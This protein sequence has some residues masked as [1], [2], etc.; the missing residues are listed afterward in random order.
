[1]DDVNISFGPV[2]P[3]LSPRL[4][5]ISMPPLP[6]FCD[7]K[8]T[9]ELPLQIAILIV[10]DWKTT[11]IPLE[12][13]V[14]LLNQK[15]TLF[16]YQ[17]IALEDYTKELSRIFGR[18]SDQDKLTDAMIKGEEISYGKLQLKHY[19]NDIACSLKTEIGRRSDLFDSR[20]DPDYFIFITT[21]KHTD[22]NFFQEDGTNGFSFPDNICRGAIIMTGHHERKFA[23]PTVIEFIFKFIFRISV[24]FRFP[25]FRRKQ[26]HYSQ[27]SCL[28]DFNHDIGFV[29]HLV[30]HN[31]I[32]MGC[33][34][35][36]G[37]EVSEEIKKALDTNNLYGGLIE[38]H[39]AKISSDLGFN[40]SLV[41]GIY[42]TRWE[43]MSETISNSF[44]S[45]LGSLMAVSI[46]VGIFYSTGSDDW[47][48]NE[49]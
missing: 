45:R 22:V 18:G 23:P 15:Q 8:C 47:F 19:V 44:F 24:K 21:S 38:R 5:P 41:K 30:L 1:M 39:P 9:T 36:L 6:R 27:K 4:P 33:S 11:K 25:E 49:D 16:E 43:H 35:K 20:H 26:R 7:D 32:C 10:G 2:T 3:P 28:F 34:Q 17:L 46:M 40:L 12:F 48:L 37:E 14:L 31:Y 42:K 13:L 29:R